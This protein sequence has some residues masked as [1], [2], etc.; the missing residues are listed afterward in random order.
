[1]DFGSE[2]GKSFYTLTAADTAL[3]KEAMAPVYAKWV[4]NLPAGID[5]QAILDRIDELIAQ[6]GDTYVTPPPAGSTETTVAAAAAT[7][8]FFEDLG[9]N[10]VHI[11]VVPDPGMKFDVA[12]EGGFGDKIEAFDAAGESLGL[13]EL[14]ESA[15]GVLDY[16]SIE[17]I[18]KLIVTDVPHGNVEYEYL[19]P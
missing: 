12:T 7:G 15:A 13:V 3:W 14:L 9:N 1:M 11:T 4:E 10:K 19:I 16:S 8:I 18:A 17:G 5:G 6:Y 2:P